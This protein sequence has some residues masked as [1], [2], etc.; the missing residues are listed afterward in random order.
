M[1]Q[2]II[3]AFESGSDTIVGDY[4]DL[5]G[6][7]GDGTGVTFW[8]DLTRAT[9]TTVNQLRYAFATQRWLERANYGGNNYYAIIIDIMFF[10]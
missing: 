2:N 6:T 7:S 10:H 1:E 4:G 3:K 9:A 8:A 5:F